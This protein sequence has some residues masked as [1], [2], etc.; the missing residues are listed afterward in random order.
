MFY[1]QTKVRS[2]KRRWMIAAAVVMI[3]AVLLSSLGIPVNLV[4]AQAQQPV[5]RVDAQGNITRDGLIFRVHGGSWFG[6]EGR[7]EPSNDQTNPSGAPMEQYMGNVFWAPSAR[8]YTQDVN[9]FKAMGINLVR[10]PLSPQTLDANNPQGR[11]PYL[12]NHESVQIANS[13]LALETVIKELDKVGIMV[14]LDIHSCSNYIGWRAGR[15]DARPPWADADRD[16]YDFKRENWSCASTN[17]PPTVTNTQ[18]YDET[19]WRADLRTLAGLGTQLGVTNIMGIDIFNEPHDYNWT[20]WRR[21]IDVAYAEI[22]AVNPNILIFAQGIGTVNGTQDGTPTTFNQTPHGEAATNPNWGENLFEAGANPPTMPKNR[23]V[24]S[25]HTYGPSVFVQKMFMDPAQPQCAGL[26]GDA[27]GDADCN[28]VINPTLLRQG[29]E[30]HF[31][32]LK[33]QGYAIVIG[34]FGGNMDWPRGKASLRDQARWS[35]ITD[36]TIDA[37]WQNAFVDYLISAGI[38][39]T[40]YWSIN[41]ESGDTGGLYTTP[42]QPGSNESGWGTWGALDSRKITLLNRLWNAGPTPTPTFTPT[43]CVGC[44][45]NTFTPTPTK[46][47]TP[48]I[49]PTPSGN[50]K[51]QLS[52][53]GTDNNQQTQ[54]RYR[55][56]NAGTTAQSNLSVRIYFT[57]DG[58]NPASSYVLEKYYDQSGA[59]TVSGPTQASGSTYYFTVNYG[60]TSLAA[61]GTWEFQTSLHLNNWGSTYVGTNDWWHTASALPASYTDWTTI[62]AYVSGGRVWGDEPVVGPTNTP[63]ITFTPSRTPTATFTPTGVTNTPTR[64]PT[65]TFTPTATLTQGPGACSPVTATIAAPFTQDGAGTFCWQTSNLGSFINSWNLASLTINGV[66]FTNQYVPSSSYPARINGFWYVSYT[67]NFPWSHFEAK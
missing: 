18:P 54:F 15:F 12:K 14:L 51:V 4:S 44:P 40:I 21:L 39:D 9:E 20:E 60:S 61:G 47:N 23:L 19:K 42:Y 31:G 37:Q 58:S 32:Y 48:T 24:Y 63:T 27:A 25:P 10:I 55:V 50:L 45:T 17:N 1:K 26:E 28:I 33:A 62:P 5:W 16:N 2:I 53:S 7:H 11:A 36:N 30:E 6:L 56:Q 67:G 35:H 64:T 59:A 43:T 49:T 13:R 3:A 57:T 52:G 46:T 66:N 34:E 65:A 8:T 22:N 41:P 29:W 38:T